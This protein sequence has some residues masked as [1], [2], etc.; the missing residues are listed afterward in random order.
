[1]HIYLTPFLDPIPGYG[2]VLVRS[3]LGINNRSA[4]CKGENEHVFVSSSGDLYLVDNKAQV[5][6][7]GY[8]EYLGDMIENEVIISY[9]EYNEEFYI[10]DGQKTYL[11]TRNGLCRVNQLVTSIIYY[12]DEPKAVTKILGV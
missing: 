5:T 8:K 10:C 3:D 9:D 1:M 4:V 11:L 12:D 6:K 2:S 7:L